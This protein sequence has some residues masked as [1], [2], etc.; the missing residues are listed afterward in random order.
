MRKQ[1][2]VG[3]IIGLIIV[4]GIAGVSY[5]KYSA[6]QKATSDY[7]NALNGMT[8]E[9]TQAYLNQQIETIIKPICDTLIA[10]KK[11]NNYTETK[12]VCYHWLAVKNKDQSLCDSISENIVKDACKKSLSGWTEAS[13][14]EQI[15]NEFN[16]A[17]NIERARDTV[18]KASLDA[19]RVGAEMVY[20]ISG[21]YKDVNCS[22]DQLSSDCTKIKNYTGKNPTFN[23]SSAAYCVYIKLS[24]GNYY[25]IDSI[26]N[27][28]GASSLAGYCSG[29]NYKCQ[30]YK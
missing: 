3:I 10:E 5:Y 20:E 22:N 8:N 25:C 14:T 17:V 28:I 4:G 12:D 15:I 26:G 11:E 16:T 1:I 6:E 2:L 9:Q 21:G 7:T 13:T 29:Q 23:S 30:E 27:N 24:N 18:I 19:I